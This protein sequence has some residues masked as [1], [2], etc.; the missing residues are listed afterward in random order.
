M[1][2]QE[3]GN[4]VKQIIGDKLGEDENEVTP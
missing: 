2:D 4:K 1:P 3:K